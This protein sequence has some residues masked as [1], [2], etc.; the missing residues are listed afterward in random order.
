MFIQILLYAR[1]WVLGI[2]YCEC[3]SLIGVHP[4]VDIQL[5]ILGH[6]GGESFVHPMVGFTEILQCEEE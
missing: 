4:M 6:E 1:W 2:F 3:S 5:S